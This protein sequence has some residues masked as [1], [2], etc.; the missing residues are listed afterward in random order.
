MATHNCASCEEIRQISPEFVMNGITDDICTSLQNNTGI[1]PSSGNDDCEDLNLLNDCLIDTMATEVNS[2]ETCD[3][4]KFMRLFIPNVWTMFKSLICAICGLWTNVACLR[5]K[6]DI[7]TF[8]PT[9]RAFR[10]GG[11]GPEAVKYSTLVDG[12]DVGTLTVY[13]DADEDATADQNPNGVYGS[14]PADRDYIA[15]VTW[16]AD[17]Q[18]LGGAHTVVRVSLRNNTQTQAYATKRAQHYSI[19]DVD[20]ISM[21]Q[22]GFCYLPKGGHLLIRS[23]CGQTGGNGAKF[24][25]HQFS[26]VLVPIVNSDVVC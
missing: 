12:Q 9:V 8:E 6:V 24:R 15:F 7:I 13:M 23:Y 20:H 14:T 1:S 17:G 22:T 18:D 25:V 19:E 2:Y 26:M 4:K 11:T 3:W 21:N 16:C 5:K 10:G